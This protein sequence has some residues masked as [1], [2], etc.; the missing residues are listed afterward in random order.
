VPNV[1][2]IRARV[3]SFFMVR[4]SGLGAKSSTAKHSRVKVLHG[5]TVG[6]FGDEILGVEAPAPS[7]RFGTDQG[8]G[9]AVVRG[10]GNA[11]LAKGD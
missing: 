4:F 9:L 7:V 1:K 10:Y 11:I 8:P 2:E 5:L 6:L 3:K